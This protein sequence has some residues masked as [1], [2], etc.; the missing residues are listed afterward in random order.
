MQLG[1][2]CQAADIDFAVEISVNEATSH[3]EQSQLVAL[4]HLSHQ[5]QF[6]V[7]GA[8]PTLASASNPL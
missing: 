2:E 8:Y 3:Y 5:P 4:L 6:S 1:P 7:S